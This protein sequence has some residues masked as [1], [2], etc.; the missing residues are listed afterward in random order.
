MKFKNT[1]TGV[2]IRRWAARWLHFPVFWIQKI[3]INYKLFFADKNQPLI[4]ILTIGK[5]GSSSLYYSL[6]EQ[7]SKRIF[8]IH[9]ISSEGINRAWYEHK[10]STRKSVPLHLIK[11]RI[12]QKKLD[13]INEKIYFITI[14]REP[15][16]R[17]ISSFFQNLDQIQNLIDMKNLKFD[18]EKIY[19]VLNDDYFI[20]KVSEEDNWIK[21]E[22]IENLNFKVYD[23]N[24]LK[25]NG[26]LIE[27]KKFSK[28]LILKMEN[29]NQYFGP[30]LKDFF[31]TNKK[32]K[33]KNYN[34]G[35]SKFYS[36]EYSHFKEQLE[37]K[38]STLLKVY[39]TKYYKT[40]YQN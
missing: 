3:I 28:L 1:N 38:K 15:V 6:K 30:A 27:D 2:L 5:V 18:S 24:N 21:N 11:S 32:F 12:L 29:L 31:I 19:D 16:S 37:L 23:N 14:F 10:T 33:L 36:S 39:E 20:N 34:K 9:Y 4:I 22:L 7:F 25:K 8:H 35:E 17:K 13:N 40:F 26:F